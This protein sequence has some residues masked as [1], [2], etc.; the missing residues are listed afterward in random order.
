MKIAISSTGEGLDSQV[1][2]R[3]G[4]CPRYVIVEIENKE[5]KSE[6]TI[7]NPAMMQGGGAGIAAAQAIGNEKVESVITGN[8][9]PN[10]FAV[11]NQLNIEVYQA[12]GVI[13]GA[14]QQFIEGRLTKISAATGPTFMGRGIP[15]APGTGP[16][17]GRGGGR[18]MG[19]GGGG[20]Q[21]MGRGA[22]RG[23][24]SGGGG[25]RW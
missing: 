3:F 6:K 9:G 11:L 14:V 2:A 21:G 22:G 7:D 18:G 12:S 24:G 5:I 13:K 16:G 17:M 10:A 23:Q 1:D 19:R 15:V 25:G 4:R 20:G 8:I